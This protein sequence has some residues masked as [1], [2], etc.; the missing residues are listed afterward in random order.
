MFVIPYLALDPIAIHLG[1]LKIHWYG[2]AYAMGILIGWQYCQFLI[3]KRRFAIDKHHLDAFI[4]W[5]T[6]GIIAGGR[7][8]QVLFYNPSYYFSHPL[9]I[10]AIWHPGMSFH[11]GFLGVI[12]ALFWYCKKHK[13]PGFVFT[14]LIAAGVP[15][16]LFFG[17]IANYINAELVG[18][19]SDVPWATIFPGAGPL[20]RHP[21]QIYE[22][23]L[24]GVLLWSV[25]AWITFKTDYTKKRPGVILGTFMIIYGLSRILAE[26][27]REPD[28]NIGFLIGGTTWGQ[29]LS[30]PLVIA[31]VL[32]LVYV[33]KRP[34]KN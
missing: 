26:C 23:L 31:G 11:G 3:K 25:L 17:R 32:Y 12:I 4:P 30:L 18:R 6:L 29:W 22:A 1:P 8:G 9:E 33:F 2:I 21:S 14:D 34:A 24:E 19:P 16:G 27:F 5:A 7:L 28:A 15:F 13:I 10:F 20:A